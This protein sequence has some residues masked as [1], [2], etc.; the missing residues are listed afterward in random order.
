M[1]LRNP[2]LLFN[3]S[4]RSDR[5]RSRSSLFNWA[6]RKGFD[7]NVIVFD[8]GERIVWTGGFSSHVRAHQQ[9]AIIAVGQEAQ[10][11][12]TRL[13]GLKWYL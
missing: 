12:A 9:R 13:S 8:P 5:L 6:I 7:S 11:P 2:S 10:T 1:Q 4:V 3:P